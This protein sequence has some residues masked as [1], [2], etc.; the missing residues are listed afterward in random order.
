MHLRAVFLWAGML[1][2]SCALLRC[3]NSS[4]E[5]LSAE[6]QM[7]MG[8]SSLGLYPKVSK[9]Q[10]TVVQEHPR[11][12]YRCI[13]DAHVVATVLLSELRFMYR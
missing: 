8:I 6:S 7:R 1:Q 3:F 9:W 12:F 2:E 4:K 13:K 10:W 11:S 5:K